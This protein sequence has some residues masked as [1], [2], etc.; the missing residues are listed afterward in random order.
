MTFTYADFMWRVCK[1]Y[2]WTNACVIHSPVPGWRHQLHPVADWG[3]PTHSATLSL[4]SQP[5][6]KVHVER[7]Q[8]QRHGT[9]LIEETIYSLS[10]HCIFGYVY[11]SSPTLGNNALLFLVKCILLQSSSVTAFHSIFDEPLDLDLDRALINELPMNYTINQ[12]EKYFHWKRTIKRTQKSLNK[13][14]NHR[15]KI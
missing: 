11:S 13:D 7:F 2:E 1:F 9:T 12:T 10:Q 5:A 3:R 6:T 14:R 8:P 4:S 15:A